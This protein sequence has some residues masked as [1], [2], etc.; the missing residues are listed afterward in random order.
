MHASSWILA[1]VALVWGAVC[2]ASFA[3]A[4]LSSLLSRPATG[5][6]DRT[7]L[8][9]TPI[10]EDETKKEEQETD[11]AMKKGYVNGDA[12]ATAEDPSN[13]NSESDADGLPWWWELVWKLEMMKTGEPGT[14]I[15]F[16]DSANVFRT[17]IEQIY[18]GYPSL[19][20]CPLAEGALDTIADGTMFVGLQNYNNNYGSPYKLCFGPKSFLVVS[21]PVQAKHILSTNNKLYDKGILAEILEPIMGKGLIPADPETWSVRRRQIVPAFHKAWLEHMV[22]LFGFCNQPLI[23]S[24]EKISEG[25][26][27]AEME[28]YFCSVALDI[29]GL[30]VFNYNFGS[31]TKESPVIKA[32]YSALV[33]SEHRSMTPG[34]CWDYCRTREISDLACHFLLLAQT[35]ILKHTS[36]THSQLLL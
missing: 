10:K 5:R 34:M 25:D 17:N 20:G 32:V 24:L 35:S 18:G 6:L 1:L 23:A 8:F 14:E 30:S 26:R 9:S 36:L 13:R 33:E 4:P 22:G 2:V 28:T 27:K 31:V 29:I 19:D 16:G 21:D 7:T 15:T 12:H 11:T 3:P